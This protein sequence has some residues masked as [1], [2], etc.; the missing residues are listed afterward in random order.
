MKSAKVIF[1]ALEVA[2]LLGI[3]IVLFR[4][5]WSA[6]I[7]E[8]VDW[9]YKVLIVLMSYLAVVFQAEQQAIPWDDENTDK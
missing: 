1:I 5:D 9:M 4:L 3:F 8:D 2:M 7:E 6:A